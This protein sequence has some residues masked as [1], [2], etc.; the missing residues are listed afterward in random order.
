MRAVVAWRI[1]THEVA[2]SALAILG[3]F[4]AVVLVFLQ[5]GFY[6]SVPIGATFI[7]QALDFDIALTSRDYAFQIRPGTF[8]KRRLLQATGVAGVQSA[9]PFYQAYGRWLNAN[10]HLQREMFIMGVDPDRPT[11]LVPDVHDQADRIKGIDTALLDSTTR[12]EFGGRA[13]SDV[14]EVNK[15]RIRVVGEYPLGA[16]FLGLGTMV[17]SELNFSRL[18]PKDNLNN[19]HMGLI[20][21]RP[22][23]NPQTVARQLSSILPSDTTVRTRDE[24]MDYEQNYWLTTTSTGLVFGFG[25]VVAGI[26]GCAILFQTLST[27]VLRNLREYAVLKAIGYTNEYLSG[28]VVSQAVLIVLVAFGP[29]ALASYGLYDLARDATNLSIYM[30][31]IRTVMVLLAT[32]AAAIAGGMLTFRIIKKADPV[33]LF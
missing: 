26:V 31:G 18:F 19:V 30:T 1:L 13:A 10:E 7:Y 9:S 11:F 2:R 23:A 12:P 8:P 32:I 15:R 25:A 6:G 3:V 17:V 14:I 33:D 4:A 28:I 29:A 16:G 22:G 5:L 21:L 24:F 20:K 27:L